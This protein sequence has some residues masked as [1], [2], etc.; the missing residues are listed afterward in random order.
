MLCL[1]GVWSFAML[2][3]ARTADRRRDP[4]Q[5]TPRKGCPAAQ[6]SPPFAQ[7]A[8]LPEK[9]EAA[10]PLRGLSVFIHR[11]PTS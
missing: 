4:S 10:Q 6:A 11:S 1:T 2:R 7:R 8:A 9:A 3:G 5:R